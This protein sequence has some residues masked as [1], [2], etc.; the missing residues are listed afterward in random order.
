MLTCYLSLK[1]SGKWLR[2][3]NASFVRRS[4]WGSLTRLRKSIRITGL[5]G[6]LEKILIKKDWKVLQSMKN[7]GKCIRKKE[8]RK[9]YNQDKTST[10]SKL[11]LKCQDSNSNCL[12]NC[13]LWTNTKG[14]WVCAPY[15]RFKLRP[16]FWNGVRKGMM[17]GV[18]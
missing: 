12:L 4:F 8:V 3:G 2:Q 15:R 17:T 13:L 6:S 18:N 9:L 14:S 7:M 16:Q 11:F 1:L 5:S 10:D